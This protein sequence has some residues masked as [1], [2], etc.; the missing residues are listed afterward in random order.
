MTHVEAVL[1][2]RTGDSCGLRNG[3]VVFKTLKDQTNDTAGVAFSV[4]T[5]ESRH[6]TMGSVSQSGR[7]YLAGTVYFCE[8]FCIVLQEVCYG[9]PTDVCGTA[10]VQH[11][12]MHHC[13]RKE[14]DHA[15]L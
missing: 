9:D 13:G 11:H 4:R 6:F 7:L 5:I 15:S 14:L 8:T 12:L 10:C 1:L 3:P 2:R